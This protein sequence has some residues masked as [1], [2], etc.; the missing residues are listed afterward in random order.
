MREHVLWARLCLCERFKLPLLQ[1]VRAAYV[2]MY[3]VYRQYC[4]IMYQ[5]LLDS[6]L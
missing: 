5:T 4:P 3:F 1:S 6:N 2:G